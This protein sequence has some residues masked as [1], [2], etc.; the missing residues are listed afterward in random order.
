MLISPVR[1]TAQIQF[2]FQSRIGER[3]LSM[4]LGLSA[5]ILAAAMV[6]SMLLRTGV[7]RLDSWRYYDPAPSAASIDPR[8]YRDS[9]AARDGRRPTIDSDVIDSP[10][11][12]LYLPYRPRRHNSLIARA[13]PELASA[14]AK[15]DAPDNA[16]GATCLGGLYRVSLDASVLTPAYSFTRDAESDFVGLLAY[17]PTANLAPGPHTLTIDGPGSSADADREIVRIP[18][19]SVTR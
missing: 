11:L 3:R 17:V 16:A 4:A 2:M 19:Y 18:F 6:L 7:L 13:C 14:V 8:Y 1:W 9:G 15:G 10:V 12:R 5:G